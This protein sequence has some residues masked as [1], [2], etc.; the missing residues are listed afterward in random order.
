MLLPHACLYC[1]LH[2]A[3]CLWKN[4][5]LPPGPLTTASCRAPGGVPTSTSLWPRDPLVV[6]A[7]S[8]LSARVMCSLVSIMSL[9][10]APRFVALPAL[11]CPSDVLV[12]TSHVAAAR[13]HP[14]TLTVAARAL[15]T[16]DMLA[17]GLG[18]RLGGEPLRLRVHAARHP[19]PRR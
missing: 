7:F 3:S 19:T 8:A 13:P 18:D 2:A 15:L 1:C 16:T 12:V 17:T 14:P 6:S 5:V 4:P 10:V 11:P 9:R